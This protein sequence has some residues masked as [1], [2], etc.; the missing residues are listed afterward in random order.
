M[1]RKKITVRVKPHKSHSK[2]GKVEHVKGY[3]YKRKDLGRPG[4]GP[5]KIKI[6]HPKDL[7]KVGYD[8]DHKA[9]SRRRALAKAV[10][11]YGYAATVRK[12]NAVRNLT[13]RSDPK[14]SRIYSSDIKFLQEKYRR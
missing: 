11:K 2:K 10:K 6:K 1:S 13:H 9:S 8:P 14:H 12:L 3:S 7:K 5:K 4:K